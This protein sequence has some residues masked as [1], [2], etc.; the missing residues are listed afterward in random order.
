MCSFTS[1]IYD[2]YATVSC[3]PVV[4]GNM[5][6]RQIINEGLIQNPSPINRIHLLLIKA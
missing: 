5:Q 2:A 3:V 6:N 1:K 4:M